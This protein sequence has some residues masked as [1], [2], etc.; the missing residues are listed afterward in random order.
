MFSIEELKPSN[1]SFMLNG[2]DIELKP[3]D[4][5]MEVW[6]IE[7]YSDE[8]KSN[9][10]D[11]LFKLLNEKGFDVSLF[12]LLH[13]LVDREK[14][15]TFVGF[16]STFKESKLDSSSSHQM[17]KTKLITNLLNSQ[18]LIKNPKREKELAEIAKNQTGANPC[19][20]IY[21]DKIAKR[22]S[23]YTIIEFYKLTLRQLH[24]L[25]KTMPGEE[26]K[27]LEIQAALL[28]KKIPPRKQAL[29]LTI[30]EEEEA[31][32]HAREVHTRLVK[33]YEDKQKGK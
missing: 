6:V 1:V 20:G 12:K 33:E 7:N 30:K 4:L 31:D 2:I 9:G 15:P 14:F 3:F 16:L 29:D 26:H 23:A 24:G 10:K 19:Y 13:R 32:Q 22:Y 21:Y 25:L 18:P 17:I 11:N 8:E 27:E 5:S 28:G